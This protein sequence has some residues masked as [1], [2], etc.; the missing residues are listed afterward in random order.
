MLK[1]LFEKLP[2]SYQG[3][4]KMLR[5]NLLSDSIIK[6]EKKVKPAAPSHEVKQKLIGDLQLNFMSDAF[7]N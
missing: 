1:E 6:N 2:V 7:F 5:N 3:Q 4:V